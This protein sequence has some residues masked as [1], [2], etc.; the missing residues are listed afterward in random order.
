M[1]EGLHVVAFGAVG[2]PV[3]TGE[4]ARA[5]AA[6]DERLLRLRRRVP[7]GGRVAAEP[8]AVDHSHPVVGHDSGGPSARAGYPCVTGFPALV[9][10]Q[11][12]RHF[13]GAP[14]QVGQGFG[15]RALLG[16][17]DGA[18]D[19]EQFVRPCLIQL[20]GDV[21]DA[22][23][24]SDVDELL[25]WR[26]GIRG[27]VGH[28][29]RLG[30]RVQWPR[31]RSQPFDDFLDAIMQRPP[32][33]EPL[34]VPLRQ[35]QWEQHL[36]QLHEDVVGCGQRAAGEGAHVRKR[37]VAPVP[38]NPGQPRE[39]LQHGADVRVALGEPRR[40]AELQGHVRQVVRDVRGAVWWR[41]C[42]GDAQFIAVAADADDGRRA[43]ELVHPASRAG[44]ARGVEGRWP[45]PVCAEWCRVRCIGRCFGRCCGRC[46]RRC[47][48]WCLSR[49][50]N[51]PVG[52]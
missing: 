44:R 3:A 23:V 10:V 1:V 46:F 7:A 18:E 11:R 27:R 16:G 24:L 38:Q 5:V 36:L 52:R 32:S 48:G 33:L 42:F 9:D 41:A 20:R 30:V 8:G 50:C 35:D 51:R 47:F 6:D 17:A 28:V 19:G 25:R 34:P 15:T 29:G 2:G 26:I 49:C 14:H 13:A 21:G 12:H 31:Q 40:H 4:A 45:V 22:L 39:P 37:H 43:R